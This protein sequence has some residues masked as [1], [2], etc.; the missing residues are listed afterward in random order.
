MNE[1]WMNAQFIVATANLLNF[2]LPNRMFYHN[3][4]P[5]TPQQYQDKL[6]ALVPLFARLQADVIGVQEVWDEQALIDAVNLA[7]ERMATTMAT[8]RDK[9]GAHALLHTLSHREREILK[10]TNA[11]VAVENH[12]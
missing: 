8:R 10:F 2:A 11:E 1:P 9:A 4:E 12:Q 5:Y 6:A 3:T 7:L